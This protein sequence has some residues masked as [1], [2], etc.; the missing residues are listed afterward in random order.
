MNQP[1]PIPLEDA[2]ASS[3]YIPE[4]ASDKKL[5][6]LRSQT[7]HILC[8]ANGFLPFRAASIE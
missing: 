4:R 5:I 1:P 3:F 7:V 8:I 2:I 6:P